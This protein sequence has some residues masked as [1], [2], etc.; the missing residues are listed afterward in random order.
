MPEGHVIHRYAR[1]HRRHLGGQR[2]RVWS[3]QGRFDPA[4]I[5]GQE[6]RGVDALGKHLF[7]RW[8]NG[9]ILHVHLGLFGKFTR[10][11]VPAPEPT[12]ATRVAMS[13]GATVLYLAGPTICD[14]VTP[15]EVDAIAARLGPD[16]LAPGA[17]PARFAAAPGIADIGQA[18]ALVVATAGSIQNAEQTTG[19][20]TLGT[21]NPGIEIKESW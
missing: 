16:P 17:D 6:L 20:G 1:S 10:H 3:P 9:E 19:S 12:P 21:A 8:G 13:G 14:L 18:S 7:Y 5:D 4:P 2:L 11:G 15:D